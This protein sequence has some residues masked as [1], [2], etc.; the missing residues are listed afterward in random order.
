MEILQVRSSR[1]NEWI[2]ITAGVQHILRE[3]K[4]SDGCC[5]L[6]VP[7]TTA[8]V[9]I[10]EG[11]DPSVKEDVLDLL[12]R[13]APHDGSYRH[14]EGNADAHAKSSLVGASILVPIRNGNLALGTWQ[15]IFFCEFDGPR[16]RRVQLHFLPA[17][18]RDAP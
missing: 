16:S 6:F 2:D 14:A 9:T 4:I 8:A 13:L 10:N 7:H 15:A 18:S 1:R 12:S 5:L 17:P 11:A 3:K